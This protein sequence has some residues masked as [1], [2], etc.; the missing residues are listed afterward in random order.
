M[1]VVFLILAIRSSFFATVE[2]VE[3]IFFFKLLGD[4]WSILETQKIMKMYYT[5]SHT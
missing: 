2:S 4:I 3:K 1:F 5:V